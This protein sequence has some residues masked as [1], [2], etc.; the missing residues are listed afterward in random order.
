MLGL[1]G[2]QLH[3]SDFLGLVTHERF[4]EEVLADRSEGATRQV[5]DEARQLGLIA[6]LGGADKVWEVAPG[7]QASLD[8]LWREALTPEVARAVELHYLRYWAATARLYSSALH[9]EGRAEWGAHYGQ[10]DEGNLR[11]ALDLAE[12][13]RDWTAAHAI[14]R[15]LLDLW[16]MQGRAKDARHLLMAWSTQVTGLRTGAWQG[17]GDDAL[18]L[19][20]FLLSKRANF[21]LRAGELGLASALYRQIIEVLESEADP[22]GDMLAVT[23]HELG[24]VEQGRGDMNAAEDWYRK[25]L[26][27]AETLGN[28]R[29]MAASYHHLGMVELVRGKLDEAEVWC[30][31]SLDIYRSLGDQPNLAY[32]Y[33]HLGIIEMERGDL[34]TAEVWYRRSL[35]I[36]ESLGDRF[37]VA[38]SNFQLGMVEQE[39]GNLDAAENAYRV[40]LKMMEAIGD[41]PNTARVFG[42]L[43]LLYAERGQ[44][45]AALRYM[46]QAFAMF[47][48]VDP[49]AAQIAASTLHGL[50]RE[51]GRESFERAWREMSAPRDLLDGLLQVF[52]QAEAGA[53]AEPAPGTDPPRE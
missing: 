21:Y 5:L 2:G 18:R 42:Q 19:W 13:E 26:E 30:R 44:P 15:L 29:G 53:E 41:R 27:V 4:P 28:R 50:F 46:I 23:Y 35:K 20:S 14:L 32:G 7:A 34:D 47:V 48:Q 36:K 31:K 49:P 51:L 17:A 10:I 40:S 16:P 39:R 38:S 22:A 24:M 1:F 3:E 52:A 8:R 11:K 25:S 45:G 6:P 33:H 37:G 12:R 43:G 9:S